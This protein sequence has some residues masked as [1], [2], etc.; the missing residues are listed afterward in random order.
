MATTA[1]ASNQTITLT[2]GDRCENHVGMQ[3]IGTHAERGFRLDDLLRV[4][5]VFPDRSELYALHEVLGPDAAEPEHAYLLV[6]RGFAEPHAGR[7]LWSELAPLDWDKKAFLR[8]SVKNKRARYNL[9]FSD[10][11]QEPDY[12]H[13]KGRVY[14]VGDLPHLAA[15]QR[16]I[17]ALVYPDPPSVDPSSAAPNRNRL[18]CE[19]NYYYDLDTT[20]I[21]YHGDAERKAVVG[22]RL[23]ASMPLWFQW[24]D[25]CNG[26]NEKKTRIGEPVAV[27]LHDGDMYIMRRKRRRATTGCAERSGRFATPPVCAEWWSGT[28]RNRAGRGQDGG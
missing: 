3:V 6:V 12:E 15:L 22:L 24:F 8:N 27:D 7:H 19:G 28:P 9:C 18:Q 5:A 23:G 14:D 10:F 4:Q 11:C 13:K 20:Y 21:G 26:R 25:L 17:T 1:P 16:R 2:F